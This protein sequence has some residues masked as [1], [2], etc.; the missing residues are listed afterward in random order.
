M[1]DVIYDTHGPRY[2]DAIRELTAGAV[3]LFGACYDGTTSFRPGAR[4]G[5]DALR[6][7]SLGIETYSPAQDMDTAEDIELVDLGN[8]ELPAGAPAPVVAAVTWAT[9][10]ILAASAKPFLLGGEHSVSIGAIAAHAEYY[11]DLTLVQLDAHADLRP[12]YLDEPYSHACVMCRALDGLPSENV[13]QVGV[14]SGTRQEFDELR[15]S[16]RLVPAAAESLE[17]RLER[18]SGPIYLTVDLDVFDPALLPGTGTPE[19]GGIDWDTF[20]RLLAVIPAR[21]LV[22][23]DVVELA[24]GLDATGRSAVLAAKVVREVALKLGS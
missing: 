4:F 9:R 10:E 17:E 20:A 24:P 23:A 21:R 11:A 12:E 13:L 5:P 7:A 22:A 6:A 18:T 14:R 16:G 19:P 15:Q 1:T 2:A 3:A 8:L